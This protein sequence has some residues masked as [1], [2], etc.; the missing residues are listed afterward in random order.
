MK[1]LEKLAIKILVH[2]MRKLRMYDSELVIRT[3]G[4]VYFRNNAK[5]KGSEIKAK[6]SF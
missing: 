5:I 4:I 1:T 2:T 3:D 6:T